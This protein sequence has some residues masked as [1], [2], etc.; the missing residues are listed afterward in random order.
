MENENDFLMSEN[1]ELRA[2]NDEIKRQLDQ[3][4]P[5]KINEDIQSLEN[6]V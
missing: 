2:D 1:T 4:E 6:E 5:E 3:M